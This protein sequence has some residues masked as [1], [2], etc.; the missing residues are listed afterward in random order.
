MVGIVLNPFGRD[1]TRWLRPVCR[2]SCVTGYQQFE[3]AEGS[4][5]GQKCWRGRIV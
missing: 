2:P 5:P 3:Y 4:E 1:R